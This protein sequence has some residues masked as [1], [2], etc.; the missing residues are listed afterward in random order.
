M[1]TQ[2]QHGKCGRTSIQPAL[3]RGRRHKKLTDWGRQ[4]VLQARRWLPGRELVV[5]A[6]NG[7]A[8]LEFLAAI[9]RHGVACVTR[10]VS[11]R[12]VSPGISDPAW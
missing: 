10:L 2:R 12:R 11:I 5:V 6:D 8:A 3:T 9:S 7:F 4:L 1:T